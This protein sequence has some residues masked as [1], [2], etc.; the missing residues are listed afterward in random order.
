MPEF[1]TNAPERWFNRLESQFP[2]ANITRSSTKFNHIVAYL[3][4][5]VAMSVANLMDAVDPGA[6]DSSEKLKAALIQGSRSPGG[7]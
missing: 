6:A 3:P 4:L 2:L 5:K 1:W 7:S